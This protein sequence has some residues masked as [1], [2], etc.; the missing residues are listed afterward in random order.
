MNEVKLF[1]ICIDNIT[2]EQLL[3]ELGRRGGIVF[4]PNVDHLMRL[5]KDKEFYDIYNKS[6]YRVCDSQIV[7]YASRLLNQPITEKI[8]GSDL[9]PAFYNY[10]RDCEEITIFLLGAA[11]GVAARAK[12]KINEKVGREMVVDCYSPPFGFEKDELECQRIVDRINHS[13]ASV[14]AIGVGAPKQEKWIMKH[15]D[16]LNH[17]KIFL[18]I[19]ATIDFEAGEKPRS[20]Q[21]ISEAGLEWLHRL[22]SEPLRLW[23]RYLIEDM[24]FFLLLM[25]QK[26]NLY[27]SPFSSLG[28]MAIP[29]WQM[30]LLGQILQDAGL[31]DELQVQRVLAIQDQRHNLRFGEIVTDLG[32]LRQETVD[33]FAEQ[34]PQIGG[35]QQRQPLGYYLKQAMLLDDQQINLILLEQQQKYLRFGELAVQKRWLKQQTVDSILSYLTQSQTEMLL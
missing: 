22:V 14:L 23:K 16:K 20:P 10:Y 3:E 34:L 19:G 8:S 33:F 30:P 27:H 11:E 32:W 6:D 25:Q 18:A 15:K 26:L 13:K 4:T 9:F 2:T 31:L 24:P 21:W 7:Y 12:V 17:A 29:N 5:Q 35:S 1:N 28:D